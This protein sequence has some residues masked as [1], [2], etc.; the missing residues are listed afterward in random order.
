MVGLPDRLD[1]ADDSLPA[2]IERHLDLA[3]RG[4]RSLEVTAKI[5]RHP[6]RFA[7]WIADG[8]G[9]DGLDLL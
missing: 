1:S 6:Q 3:V 4:V 2:W 8:L 9:H 5:S 7:T